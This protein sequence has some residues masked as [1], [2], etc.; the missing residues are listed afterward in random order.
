MKAKANR[1][2]QR[3]VDGAM[4]RIAP[5]LTIENAMLANMITGEC[6]PACV[7]ILDGIVIRVRN[8]EETI[9][10][11]SKNSYDA[12]GAYLLPGF[13][14]VHMHI[15][16]TMMAPHN[17]AKAAVVWG[18][19]TAVTDPH[20]LG[21]ILGVP[22]VRYMVEDSQDTKMR[23][24]T[25]A[26]SCVPCSPGLETSGAEF[27]A[28][29]IS[30][31]LEMPGVLGIGELMD[32]NNIIHNK[33]RMPAIL[34]AGREKNAFLQG[35]VMAR[36][37]KEIAAYILAGPVSDHECRTDEDCS[38][39][40][41][42]G[43]HIDMK[44]SSHADYMKGYV[45][46][47]KNTPWTDNVTLCTDDIHANDLYEKGHMN[48]V[49]KRAIYYGIDPMRAYRFA[50]YQAAKEYGFEDLGAIAPGYCADMQLLNALDGSKPL[51][52]WVDGELIAQDGTYLHEDMRQ[53]APFAN[54]INLAAIKG[55]ENFVLKAPQGHKGSV[56]TALVHHRPN[57][58]PFSSMDY[59]EMQINEG[60]I[61]L[62]QNQCV[63]NWACSCN[64]YGKQQK[65]IVPLDH[66]GLLEGAVAAT[67]SHDSHNFTVVYT[68][69]DDAYL[70]A[71]TLSQCGGGI[72]VTRNGKVEAILELPIGGVM[73]VLECEPLAKQ[74]RQVEDAL[75][76]I[77]QAPVQLLKIALLSL[78]AAPGIHITD[79]G[80]VDGSKQDFVPVF[81]P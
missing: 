54:T 25:L 23:L 67:V 68:N 11:K 15:E 28:K 70:A 71:Q 22:G 5:D 8:P 48:H 46:A 55:P 72:C 43:L 3:L 73:S 74:V 35:H 36:E 24:Y 42:M 12:K 6:Y 77:T 16:V 34:A 78:P 9:A 31:I 26:P 1:N 59:V 39:K 62:P 27:G 81:L 41:R 80:L 65:T 21:N 57:G 14:D 61:V 2:Y 66:F 7:D 51:A 4:Q 20:E 69:A 29:E 45:E 49:V 47:V 64:R 40:M 56:L 18:T 38:A 19:T 58:S 37:E 50:T 52:V 32:Y 75:N 63:V 17:F 60:N 33:G 10:L 30:E 44:S 79:L 53:P 76:A 13:V